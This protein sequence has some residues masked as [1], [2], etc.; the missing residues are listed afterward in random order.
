MIA[1]PF[2]PEKIPPNTSW[3]DKRNA[4]FSGYASLIILIKFSALDGPARSKRGPT[5]LPIRIE[6]EH[7]FR[8]FE[9]PYQS[10]LTSNPPRSQYDG[11]IH[12]RCADGCTTYAINCP[13][14]KAAFTYILNGTKNIEIVER[15]K[16][17]L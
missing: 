6:I 5:R 3:C 13:T 2:I 4:N 15:T 9:I 7:D 17:V 10:T 1:I 12:Q 11:A 8:F 14:T 16:I